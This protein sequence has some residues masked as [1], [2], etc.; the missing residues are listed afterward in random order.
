MITNVRLNK[1]DKNL[2][3]V[4]EPKLSI[5]IIV[6]I[7]LIMVIVVSL[8]LSA[9]VMTFK[10]IGFIILLAPALFA[11]FWGLKYLKAIFLK[12]IVILEKELMYLEKSIFIF[13]TI[14]TYFLR[15][16]KK[17]RMINDKYL[18]SKHELENIN[19]SFGFGTFQKE[20]S[21]ISE[22]GNISFEYSGKQVRFG[23][24]L[25]NEESNF[26]IENI[27][28]YINSPPLTVV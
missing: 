18:S 13:G 7:F 10:T 8:L 9:I 21:F 16:V 4:I 1:T 15:D 25:L 27:K 11:F 5:G 6:G 12:E 19:D 3:I 17:L 23:R 20:S 26:I 24:N 2:K 22:Q 28:N 14:K